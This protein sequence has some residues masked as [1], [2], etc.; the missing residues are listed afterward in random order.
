MKLATPAII[1]GTMN[2]EPRMPDE[3][4]LPKLD[5]WIAL[6]RA[7]AEL[8]NR[9]LPKDLVETPVESPDDTQVKSARASAVPS[10]ACSNL[11]VSNLASRPNEIPPTNAAM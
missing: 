10:L 1:R 7:H 2:G 3:L 9:L 4:K 6:R 11:W 8:Y 5:E